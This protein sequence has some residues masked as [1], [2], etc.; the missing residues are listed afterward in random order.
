[1]RSFLLTLE[2]KFGR[3]AIPGLLRI[4]I[5][6]QVVV[7]LLLYLGNGGDGLVESLYFFPPSMTFNNEWWRLVTFMVIPT[8]KG[9]LWLLMGV[10]FMWMI[11]EGLE[12]AWGSFR[13]NLY[14]LACI[15][16][17]DVAGFFFG[18]QVS[19]SQAILSSAVMAY[20]V[21]YPD[22]I[23]NLYGIIPL[24]MKW[25]G[26]TF[27]GF[28]VLGALGNEVLRLHIL[29]SLIPFFVVFGPG[30]SQ[31]L[32]Q[33]AN[34]MERRQRFAAGQMSEGESLHRCARCGKTDKDNPR[35]DFRVTADGEDVCSD[36]RALTK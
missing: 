26:L 12:E 4:I 33:K 21:Y 10:P 24:K 23:I 29:V 11:S 5:T 3:F 32:R 16:C 22:Q 14:L 13:V 36:C 2:Q 20:A 7:W 27:F 34:T 19:D 31:L 9:F 1:M 28:L 18:V 17:V 25:I 15:L 30:F 6:L 35:L 8:G